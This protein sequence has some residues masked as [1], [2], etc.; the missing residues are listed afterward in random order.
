MSKRR[1]YSVCTEFGGHRVIADSVELTPQGRLVLKK[2]GEDV[3]M[4]NNFNSWKVMNTEELT[5][6]SFLYDEKTDKR[7]FNCFHS[8]DRDEDGNIKCDL[9]EGST[10][11]ANGLSCQRWK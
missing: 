5:E 11:P 9:F 7:C 3:A 6:S 8:Y 10:F 1:M 4:F 2:D